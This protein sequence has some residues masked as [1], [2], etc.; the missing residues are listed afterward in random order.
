[1]RSSVIKIDDKMFIT[2]L[3]GGDQL[4]VARIRGAQRIHGN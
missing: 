3:V 1:M 2:T 4:T